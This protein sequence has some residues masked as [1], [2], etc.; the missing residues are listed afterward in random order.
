MDHDSFCGCGFPDWPHA[1]VK[2]NG[3]MKKFIEDMN[4]EY[5]HIVYG[6]ITDSIIE[7]CNL[8]DIKVKTN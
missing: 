2:L 4:V 8:L 7:T 1:Y 5:I 6:D 3:S